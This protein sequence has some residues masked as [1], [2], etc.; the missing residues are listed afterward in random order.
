VSAVSIALQSIA[1]AQGI[2]ATGVVGGL[3][4]PQAHALGNG[5][6]AFGLGNALEPQ[7]VSQSTRSV[8]HVLGVGLAPGLRSS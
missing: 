1:H 5:T 3:S 6:P 2:N 4:I 7:S 8:S